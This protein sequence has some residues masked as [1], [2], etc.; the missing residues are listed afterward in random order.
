V[1][2]G[3]FGMFYNRPEGNVTFSQVNLP[4]ILAITEFDNGNLSNP[5]GGVPPTPSR[6]LHHRHRPKSEAGVRG[7]DEPGR[8]AQLPKNLFV[9]VSGVSGLGRHLLRQPN[10]NFPDLKA[11]A[12]NPSYSTIYFN[13]YPGYTSIQ[14]YLSDATS[15]YYALQTFVSKRAGNVLFTGSYTWSKALADASGK[16]TTPRT[17]RTATSTTDPL[18]LTAATLCGDLHLGNAQAEAG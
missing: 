14:Q 6:R 8:A 9:E 17:T 3:G 4:P 15:N 11:V 2:R 13:P 12:A 10:I 5:A 7:A 1:I 18:P 16:A